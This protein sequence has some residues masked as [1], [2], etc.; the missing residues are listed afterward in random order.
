MWPAI[1]VAASPSLTREFLHQTG[2]WGSSAP[3]HRKHPHSVNTA[4]RPPPSWRSC[5]AAT[6]ETAGGKSLASGR[7]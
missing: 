3:E 7:G 6:A 2:R 5:L 4:A 1:Q